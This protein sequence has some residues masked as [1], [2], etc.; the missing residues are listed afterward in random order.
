[1]TLHITTI[2]GGTGQ[3]PVV[4]GLCKLL[5]DL[6]V[7]LNSIVGTW[8]SGGSS[9]K[10]RDLYGIMPPGDILKTIMAYVPPD[11]RAISDALLRRFDK[12]Y[13]GLYNHNAGNL[14]LSS[15]QRQCGIIPAIRALE[16]TL[17][18]IGKTHPITECE[19]NLHAEM[20]RVKAVTVDKE[21]E[22]D[23]RLNANY[24]I[25][26][27]WLEP[28]I[29]DIF[30]KTV[31]ENTD[32]LII[33][34]GSIFTS[35]MPHFTIKDVK[36]TCKKIKTRIMMANLVDKRYDTDEYVMSMCQWMDITPTHLVFNSIK[37]DNDSYKSQ[38]YKHIGISH[39]KDINGISCISRPVMKNDRKL[40]RHDPKR[41]GAA[42]V[43]I[44]SKEGII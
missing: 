28:E 9:G 40:L 7:E 23:D 11:K 18:A 20:Q 4:V 32:V 35:I 16:K 14:L 29:K 42:I 10:L 15:M 3:P 12:S 44:L 37:T 27:L 41:T 31:L 38:G 5:H 22:I 1:M 8:D 13:T 39:D 6:D 36:Q 17:D 30:P 19:T 2:G 43:E 24:K 25:T 21:D 33:S 34:P 26:K